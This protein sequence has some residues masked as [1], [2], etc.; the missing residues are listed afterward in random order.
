MMFPRP[1]SRMAGAAAL[2]TLITPLRSI[3]EGNTVGNPCVGHDGADRPVPSLDR[4]NYG[5]GLASV[6][7][8]KVMV[9]AL[10]TRRFNVVCDRTSLLFE[11]VRYYGPVA[12]PCERVGRSRTDPYTGTGD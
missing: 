1:A 3:F 5:I 4:R 6:H 8:V 11:N 10:T 7:D 9:L 12:R 2:H